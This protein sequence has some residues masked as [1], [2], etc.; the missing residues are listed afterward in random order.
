[1]FSFPLLNLH[2]Y[3]LSHF[4][5][6]V[7]LRL[8]ILVSVLSS[9]HLTKLQ[10]PTFLLG[11]KYWVTILFGNKYLVQLWM[12][13]FLKSMVLLGEWRD[14]QIQSIMGRETVLL[15]LI[16]PK[17]RRIRAGAAFGSRRCRKIS[18]YYHHL[19]GLV[20]VLL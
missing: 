8:T 18:Q 15:I 2:K 11:Y 1:M 20:R 13:L 16:V 4:H 9:L 12:C 14:R 3:Y 7:S 6:C 19:L 5:I 17:R 10:N